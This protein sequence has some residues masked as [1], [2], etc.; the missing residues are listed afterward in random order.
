VLYKCNVQ[1]VLSSIN[2][3]TEDSIKCALW[4]KMCMTKVKKS[5]EITNKYGNKQ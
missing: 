4:N 1:S 5:L 2:K 3:Q